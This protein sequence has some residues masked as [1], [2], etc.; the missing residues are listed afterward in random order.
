MN[1]SA[2]TAAAKRRAN[3]TVRLFFWLVGCGVFPVVAEENPGQRLH[4]FREP[5]MGTEFTFRVW[6]QKRR[7]DEVAGL[8]DKAFDRVAE[9][10]R[11]A[12]DYLPESEINDFARAPTG[13]PVPVSADLYLLL[14][15]GVELSRRTDGAF[16]VTAGPLIRLW[17]ISRKNRRLPSPE[18]IERARARTGSDLLA[19]D[20]LS[21]TVTKKVDGMLFDLGGIAKG[22]AADEAL[23]IFRDGGFPRA[24]VAA[25]GDIVA[26]DP[27]PGRE[28]WRIGIEGLDI[29]VP[30]ADL[31]VVT[32][33]NRAISTS[34]D[35]RRYF[36]LEGVRYSHIVS[37]RTSLGLTERI[38][39]SVIA[40]DAITSDSHATAVTLLGA[41]A[42][43]R[44]IEEIP[45]VECR[46][47]RLEGE[48]EVV[49]QSSGFPVGD[50]E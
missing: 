41:D 18:A 33:A 14:S 3:R 50:A 40:P 45:D 31:P 46:I 15:R 26:A 30:V 36:E 7:F 11:I 37:T 5:H 27:P 22:Y 47:V 6:A 23:A 43:L 42:G 20:P 17:R 28:G 13:Q 24:L 38:G 16:D 21:R 19:F 29:D 48:E 2:P 44:W 34:G 12:S 49:V 4:T 39:A 8:A 10:N 32:L 9:L 25:S 35:T 1:R